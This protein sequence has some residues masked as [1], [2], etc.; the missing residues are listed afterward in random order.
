MA[1]ISISIDRAK[2]SAKSIRKNTG[3]YGEYVMF[4]VYPVVS[5]KNKETN[6]YE[7]EMFKFSCI[8]G[9]YGVEKFLSQVDM[10]QNNY[11]SVIDGVLKK[12]ETESVQ[13]ISKNNTPYEEDMYKSLRLDVKTFSIKSEP[14]K[15]GTLESQESADVKH[16][17]NMYSTNKV[18]DNIPF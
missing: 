16:Y 13:R 11:I 10:N 12:F 14:V 17:E 3:E 7:N 9:K 18:D 15:E 2:I 8:I 4:D 1:T 5:W 6:S